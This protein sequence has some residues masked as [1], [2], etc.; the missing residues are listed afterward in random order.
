[1]IKK[2][3]KDIYNVIMY[4]NIYISNKCCSFFC[5]SIYSGILKKCAMFSTKHIKQH[6]FQHN[7]DKKCFF[8]QIS[9][10]SCD[11]E[12]WS[13]DAKNSVCHHRNKLHFKIY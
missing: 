8:E 4:K 13:N 9:E 7:N 2:D 10:G 6:C 1:M 3:S 5:C 11:T 12:D